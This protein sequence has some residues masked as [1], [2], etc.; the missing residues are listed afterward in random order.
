VNSLHANLWFGEMECGDQIQL[1][2]TARFLTNFSCGYLLGVTDPTPHVTARVR[3]YLNDG[4]IPWYDTY[5]TPGTIV[6]D[7]DWFPVGRAL[8][9]SLVFSAGSEF[10]S[11]GLYLPSSDITWTI[12]FQ[13]LVDDADA[14]GLR[15]FSPPVVGGDPPYSWLN[16]GGGWSRQV[17][18]GR[19]MD[20]Q[21]KFEATDVPEPSLTAFLLLVVGLLG[22]MRVRKPKWREGANT[23]CS[24]RADCVAVSIRTSLGARH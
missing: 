18:D 14:A 19:Q 22:V 1:A 6:Y 7:S 20:F 16:P 4:P 24:G 21:A 3:F 15:V 17:F 9:S 8:P 11:G 2:G 10:P 13:G 12:Q 5:P 23:C